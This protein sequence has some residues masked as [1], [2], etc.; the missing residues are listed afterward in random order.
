MKRNKVY[1][2]SPFLTSRTTGDKNLIPSG[3]N[4]TSAKDIFPARD[5]YSDAYPKQGT[6]PL[7]THDGFN[8]HFGRVNMK[9][10]P[11]F[12]VE[13]GLKQV[14][15][16]KGTLFALEFVA[17]AFADLKKYIAD[18]VAQGKICMDGSV[19][20]TFEATLAWDTDVGIHSLYNKHVQGLYEE[21]LAKYLNS[22][23]D[24]QIVDF[25][26]F[27]KHFLAYTSRKVNGSAITRIAY[28]TS[29]ESQPRTSGM[30]IELFEGDHQ[31]DYGK[32]A[33]FIRDKNFNVY[34]R[35][36]ERHGFLV[37]KNA[38]WRIFADI[39]NPY[40]QEK[41]KA[42]GVSSVEEAFLTYF[43]KA[44]DYEIENLKVRFFQMYDLF[45]KQ[46]PDVTTVKF[47]FIGDANTSI[48]FK[49]RKKI[50]MEELR[51]K[52]DDSY[53]LRLLIY[54]RA[55]ETRKM[56]DQREFEHVVDEA[57]KYLQYIGMWRA[58]KFVD[59]TFKHSYDE[60]AKNTEKI[61]L[62]EEEM[63]DRLYSKKKLKKEYSQATFNF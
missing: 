26:S 5:V 58:I 24:Q 37:D 32:Y 35:A 7:D 61:T 2:S 47:D 21:F 3:N 9:R 45:V 59:D 30:V 49:S 22:F 36:C 60:L 42:Y 13:D 39:T 31:D 63:C 57:V 20:K 17:D 11:I 25:D 41:M 19:F 33:G 62:T 6:Q 40:M 27:M 55:M 14:M 34:R 8:Y 51:A 12:L 44:S 38:P 28:L 50:T 29:I 56:Y 18:A 23:R 48:G 53:W 43:L 1:Q 16:T 54:F 52:Y 10:E 15:T 46:R 4:K